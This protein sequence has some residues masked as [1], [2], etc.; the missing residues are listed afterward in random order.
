VYQ[1]A[2]LA[3]EEMDAWLHGAGRIDEYG[4][5][6]LGHCAKDPTTAVQEP[7]ARES[8]RIDEKKT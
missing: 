5:V 1:H 3:L 6:L 4:H 2:Q 8:I 7:A